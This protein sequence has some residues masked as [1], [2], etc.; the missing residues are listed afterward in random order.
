MANTAHSPPGD[1]TILRL[2]LTRLINGTFIASVVDNIKVQN[3]S[4]SGKAPYDNEGA[5]YYV[6]IVIFIYGF[7]IILLIGSSIKKSKQ[8]MG[9]HRYMKNFDQIRR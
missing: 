8:D 2:K 9:V 4:L 7:S 3:D 6:V 5:L 1:K